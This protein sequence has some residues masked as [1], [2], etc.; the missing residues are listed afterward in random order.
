MLAEYLVCEPVSFCFSEIEG[1]S[2]GGV[3][4]GLWPGVSPQFLSWRY[5][6]LWLSVLL[7]D[8]CLELLQPLSSP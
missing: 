5:V 4:K 6:G 7:I 3:Y 1:G 8:S 2:G